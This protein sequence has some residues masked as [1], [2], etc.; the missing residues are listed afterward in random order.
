MIGIRP[1][2]LV[3]VHDQKGDR[4][5]ATNVEDGIRRA[6]EYAAD[7]VDGDTFRIYVVDDQ[8]PYPGYIEAW[9][10]REKGKINVTR[11]GS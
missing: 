9:V 10:S 11:R 7:G 2:V 5:A 8:N 3:T 6:S 4:F 1:S